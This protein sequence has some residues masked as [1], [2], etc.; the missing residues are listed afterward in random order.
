M[1]TYVVEKGSH[2]RKSEVVQQLIPTQ[3]WA[4]EYKEATDVKLQPKESLNKNQTQVRVLAAEDEKTL[5]AGEIPA[6]SLGQ[7]ISG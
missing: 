7:T 2:T 1:A 5:A 3:S 6:Q 4:A